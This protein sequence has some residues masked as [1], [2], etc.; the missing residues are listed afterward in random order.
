MMRLQLCRPRKG[1]VTGIAYDAVH[2][3]PLPSIVPPPSG[4]GYLGGGLVALAAGITFNCAAPFRGRLLVIAALRTYCVGAPSIVPPP[5]GDGY[6]ATGV[7]PVIVV[8]AS[9]VPP[10]SGGGY[11]PTLLL[12]PFVCRLQLCRPLP[13][14]VT[15]GF[16]G[17]AAAKG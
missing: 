8:V 10:P 6:V 3:A 5:S 2:V 17:H 7:Q 15:V 1:A 13:G 14:A 4:G 16:P 9:I 12:L 11:R